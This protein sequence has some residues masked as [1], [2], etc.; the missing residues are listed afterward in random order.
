[1]NLTEYRSDLVVTCQAELGRLLSGFEAAPSSSGLFDIG[2]VA[3]I[4]VLGDGVPEIEPIRQILCDS[5]A[6]WLRS[7]VLEDLCFPRV[8]LTY[9]AALLAY[10]AQRSRGFSPGDMA[11]MKRLCEGGLIGRSEVPV[12]TQRL[13]AAYLTRCGI[14]T[15]FGDL[16]RR[17]LMKMIDK[18][19]LRVRSDEY[20]LLVVLMCAQLLRMEEQV[21]RPRD[22][23]PGSARSSHPLRQCELAAGPRICV[24]AVVL[25]GRGHTEGGAG[26]HPREDAGARGVAAGA[27]RRRNRQRVH[28]TSGARPAYQEHR[29]AHPLALHIRRFA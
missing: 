26:E 1:M 3:E 19:V 8:E 6:R 2:A 22:L 13:I 11:V 15:D 10:L 16:G 27:A 29:R 17:D 7:G 28:R 9:T 5:A 4:A 18:R 21:Q 25:A 12:L 20:D 14:E 23:P 24:R